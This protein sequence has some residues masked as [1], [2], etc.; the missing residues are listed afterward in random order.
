[1]SPLAIASFF[2]SSAIFFSRFSVF[3]LPEPLPWNLCER[4]FHA[5][6]G[7]SWRPTEQLRLGLTVKNLFDRRPFYDPNGFAGISDYTNLYGRIYS[8]SLDYRF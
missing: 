7:V 4:A 1:M 2:L 6:F 3:A 5:S 8:V